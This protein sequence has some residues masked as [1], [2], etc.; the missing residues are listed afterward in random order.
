MIKINKL[1]TSLMILALLLTVSCSSSGNPLKL[2]GDT[3]LSDYSQ[4]VGNWKGDT[5]SSTMPLSMKFSSDG[6]C[7][8]KVDGMPEVKGVCAY[9]NGNITFSMFSDK[10][11]AEMGLAQKDCEEMKSIYRV[12][13]YK[14]GSLKL[15]FKG[16]KYLLNRN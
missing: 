8:S 5:S 6:K 12:V 9:T 7:V 16:Q 14:E 13:S 2:S 3:G 15:N 1:Y 10:E 4:I 11:C